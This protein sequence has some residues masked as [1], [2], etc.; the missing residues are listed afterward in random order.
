MYNT[1]PKDFY[2][3][4]QSIGTRYAGV[5]LVNKFFIKIITNK[6][7]AD[8]PSYDYLDHSFSEDDQLQLQKEN[9]PTLYHEYIH[10]IHEVST[11]AGITQFYLNII[12]RAIFTNHVG[13]PESSLALPITGKYKDKF[14][15]INSTLQAATGGSLHQLDDRLIY[16]IDSVDLFDFPV[17]EPTRD[18]MAPIK[19]PMIT[20][21]YL[22]Q[23]T[24]I[25][26]QD[27]VYFGKYFIYE[28]LAHHLDQLVTMQLKMPQT[29]KRVVK[30]EYKL[31]EMVARYLFP[32]ID[33][34]SMLEM[35][36]MSLCYFNCGQR[37]IR[38]IEEAVTVGH[39]PGYLMELQNEVHDHLTEHRDEI[40]GTLEEIKKI[41]EK[42][43][44]MHAAATH[45]CNVMAA[46]YDQR[47]KKPVFEI[48]I[49]Y[50][51]HL[52]D[53]REY[54]DL[55]DMVY[56]LADDDNYL[57]DFAGTYLTNELANDLRIFLC[58][59][60]YYQMSVANV[61]EHCC[62]LYTFCPHRI[63]QEKPDQCRTKPRLSF[64]DHQ[65]Y[66][67]CHYGR[68]VAYMTGLDIA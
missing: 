62:P 27:S 50:S 23:T 4:L 5:Y 34:R 66:G 32:K 17:Y 10:Y 65:A 12:N 55:C 56:E 36:S 42:R 16:R 26:G 40:L 30:P 2:R 67:W 41:F 25:D 51:G 58:N 57:R 45:L 22:D 49:T 68:G 48:D 47:I 21:S 3:D 35:A 33:E 19:I 20:Y 59:V 24:G 53:M 8:I 9:Y 6:L 31:L 1:P 28:G 39:L 44:G 60:D 46:A 14:D 11:M 15:K 13:L 43:A 7:K 64:E 29:P 52:K 38:T 18:I 63:R 61:T 54:V 37:F